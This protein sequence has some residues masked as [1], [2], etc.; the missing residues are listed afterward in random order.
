MQPAAD[1]T[2]PPDRFHILRDI[3]RAA[4]VDD[5]DIDATL[6]RLLEETS[7]VLGGS[8]LLATTT[9]PRVVWG[10]RD[11]LSES[12]R[13]STHEVAIGINAQSAVLEYWVPAG[14]QQIS[15]YDFLKTVALQLSNLLSVH[16]SR[17]RERWLDDLEAAFFEVDLH[18]QICLEKLAERLPTVFPRSRLFNS[19]G[20]QIV[21]LLLRRDLADT[22][23]RIVAS[24]GEEAGAVVDVNDS[25]VG[26][27]FETADRPGQSIAVGN[28]NIPPLRDVYKGFY[29]NIQSELC[30]PLRSDV[31]STFAA[32]NFE[33]R[34]P[35]AYGT[36]EVKYLE[37]L[38][39]RL[40]RIVGAL[41]R[42][43]TS[44]ERARLGVTS[45][46]TTYWEAV[47]KI[48]AHDLTQ[49]AATLK[50]S[51]ERIASE[52]RRILRSSDLVDQITSDSERLHGLAHCLD[53]ILD[54]VEKGEDEIA[55]QLS[56]L[57]DFSAE[58]KNY[59]EYGPLSV[60]KLA[61]DAA[62][63]ARERV[64]SRHQGPSVTITVLPTDSPS[65]VAYTSA[66]LKVYIYNALENAI[67]WIRRGVADGKLPP[68]HTG[69]VKVAVTP[70]TGAGP[71]RLNRYVRLEIADNGPGAPRHVVDA[72]NDP[73]PQSVSLRETGQG[74][75][76]QAFKDFVV[77][78]DG[79]FRAR[80]EDGRGFALEIDLRAYDDESVS[81]S[82]DAEG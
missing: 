23:I 72:I 37:W 24:T 5:E 63:F 12:V 80:S 13:L 2:L 25:V 67:Y 56:T 81:K 52:S 40:T 74:F 77:G 45:V 64:G 39:P 21:Q 20:S 9:H 36:R 22:T 26:L 6:E 44:D 7:F 27:V 18:P 43:I 16:F 78:S 66:I 17:S 19:N 34:E 53:Q 61:T 59:L 10:S 11:H 3:D 48:M 54:Q 15:E 29:K 73:I 46:Q 47:A 65:V 32:L 42:Q 33:S 69:L 71:A 58:F 49:P 55:K 4:A 41:R 62:R 60:H 38:A 30:L 57:S 76:L 70:M 31:G 51:L 82:T 75:A 50:L 28:P 79:A 14:G 1:R 35:N 8:V 68:D